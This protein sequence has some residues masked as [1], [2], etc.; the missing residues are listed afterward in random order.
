MP[1]KRTTRSQAA[2]RL[3]IQKGA[4]IPRRVTTGTSNSY[5]PPATTPELSSGRTS[6]HWD[7]LTPHRPETRWSPRSLPRGL[8]QL[9]ELELKPPPEIDLS[10]PNGQSLENALNHQFLMVDAQFRF[11]ERIEKLRRK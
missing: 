5:H 11:A 10:E 6:A 9:D 4:S 1:A 8:G 3:P 2:R 7:R